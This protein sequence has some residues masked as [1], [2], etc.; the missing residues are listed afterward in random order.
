MD[1]SVWGVHE[2]NKPSIAPTSHHQIGI[3]EISKSVSS[4]PFQSV[5]TKHKT[6]VALRK[7]SQTLLFVILIIVVGTTAQIQRQD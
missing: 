5:C 4:P 3:C 6:W 7:G 1:P 2:G